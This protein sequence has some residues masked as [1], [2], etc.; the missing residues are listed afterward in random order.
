MWK[1]QNTKIVP[2]NTSPYIM[3]KETQLWYKV[4]QE[5]VVEAG[6]HWLSYT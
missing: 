5:G 1:S 2:T 6:P 4:E 3:Y